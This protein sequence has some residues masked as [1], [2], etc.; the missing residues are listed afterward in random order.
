MDNIFMHAY[1]PPLVI[2]FQNGCTHAKKVKAISYQ[3]LKIYTQW[4]A[5]VSY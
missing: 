2:S 5:W 1:K 3:I 4:Q